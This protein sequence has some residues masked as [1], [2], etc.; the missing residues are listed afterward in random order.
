LTR[1]FQAIDM[2]ARDEMPGYTSRPRG[3]YVPRERTT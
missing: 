1:L 2:V 3:D